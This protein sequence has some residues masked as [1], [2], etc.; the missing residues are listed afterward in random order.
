M[1]LENSGFTKIRKFPKVFI[2]NI[3]L[4]VNSTTVAIPLL[5]IYR[6]KQFTVGYDSLLKNKI[7]FI[8]YIAKI[9][10]SVTKKIAASPRWIECFY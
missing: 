1:Q 10:R 3:I 7:K 4:L 6:S 8:R 2:S 5:L 9:K